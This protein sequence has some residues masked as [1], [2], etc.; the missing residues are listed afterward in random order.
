MLQR[1]I[2]LPLLIATLTTTLLASPVLAQRGDP[3]ARQTFLPSIE[4][5]QDAPVE[6]PAPSQPTPYNVQARDL[7]LE[8][9][10]MLIDDFDR[11]EEAPLQVTDE[12]RSIGVANGYATALVSEEERFSDEP[13]AVN[14]YV[15][16][17]Y[18]PEQA[19]DY[20][21]AQVQEW[22]ANPEL[23]WSASVERMSAFVDYETIQEFHVRYILAIGYKEN[24]VA[25]TYDLD[26]ASKGGNTF[27]YVEIILGKLP[28]VQSSTLVPTDQTQ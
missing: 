15:L 3:L 22:D 27:A 19:K 5:S 12:L 26:L 25:W 17:F 23:Y 4:A 1:I 21:T 9:N 18:T 20:Y 2:I 14:S 11:A 13:L 24:V 16:V 28:A 10:D 6:P 7:V 8:P